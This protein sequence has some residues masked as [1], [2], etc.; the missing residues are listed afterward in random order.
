MLRIITDSSAEFSKEEAQRLGIEIIPLTVVF[1]GRAYL[2]GV[3]ISKAEFYRRLLSGEY[4]Q[5]SQPSVTQFS[6]AFARTN[7]EETLVILISSALSGTVNTAKLAKEDGNFTQVHIYD[8]LCTTAMMRLL[9]EEAYK[10]RE[11]SVEEVVAILNDLR[12]RMRLYACIDTLEYLH[13]GGRIKRGAAIRGGLLGVR[14][15]ITI[16]EEGTVVMAGRER[17]RKRALNAVAERFFAEKCDPNYPAVFLQSDKDAQPRELMKLT[18]CE[19][20]R[21]FQI[22]CAVGTHIGPDGAGIV[23]VVKDA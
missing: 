22:C 18:G 16:S 6:E 4:P 21:I 15:I 14:P 2:E 20:A 23:Y 12:K 8:S 5:T 9:V 7:G 11:K 3:E 1:D 13:K 10:N 17:G 19:D